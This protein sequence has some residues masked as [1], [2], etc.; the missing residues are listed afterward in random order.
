MLGFFLYLEFTMEQKR[1][2][3]KSYQTEEINFW[4]LKHGD[5]FLAF[6]FVESFLLLV[7]IS[8]ERINEL[9]WEKSAGDF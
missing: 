3:E 4:I 2:I 1:A 5:S 6:V 7:T 9:V 8:K